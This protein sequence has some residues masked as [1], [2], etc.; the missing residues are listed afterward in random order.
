MGQVTTPRQNQ[1]GL[2]EKDWWRATRSPTHL[3]I[4]TLSP[5]IYDLPL[6]PCATSFLVSFREFCAPLHPPKKEVTV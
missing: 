2:A 1:Q 6:F 4:L 5:S 3:T